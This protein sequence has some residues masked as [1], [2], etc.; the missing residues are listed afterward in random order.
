MTS[1]AVRIGQ[2]LNTRPVGIILEYLSDSG[3]PDDLPG[4]KE[5]IRAL[6]ADIFTGHRQKIIFCPPLAGKPDTRFPLDPLL[7]TPRPRTFQPPQKGDTCLYY[8]M[9]RIRMRVG[10]KP[11][12]QFAV[13]RE[14]EKSASAWRKGKSRIDENFK[15]KLSFAQQEA[16]VYGLV[17]KKNIAAVLKEA[18]DLLLPGN[19][20]KVCALYEEFS[21][22]TF[23]D[24]LDFVKAHYYTE[25]CMHDQ[26]YLSEHRIPLEYLYNSEIESALSCKWEDLDALTKTHMIANCVFR[27]TYEKYGLRK[28]SWHPSH[29][30]HELG[31]QIEAHGP[32]MILGQFGEEF[33]EQG[34]FLARKIQERGIYGW[35][36][37][38]K[39]I[40]KGRDLHGIV[41]VGVDCDKEHVFFI[42][43][44]NSSDPKHPMKEKI[45]VISYG[46]LRSNIFSIYCI[47]DMTRGKPA[48]F[49]SPYAIYGNPRLAQL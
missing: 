32:H 4:Q 23:D 21:K 41:L 17:T 27:V 18:D 26:A 15:W 25:L 11:T 46:N 43:P 28:S 2:D 9:L 12:E 49:E 1:L 47:Q 29:P 20:E 13:L 34:P 22:S 37:H 24:L 35:R 33:Y 36:P 6:V 19:K 5:K 39:R 7:R 44:I 38:A 30:I 16:P 31:N 14:A 45:Y 40:D 3:N 48:F 42:D 10:K 8:A